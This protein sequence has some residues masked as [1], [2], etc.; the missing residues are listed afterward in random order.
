MCWNERSSA[1]RQ[2]RE[3]VFDPG[4]IGRTS[5]ALLSCLNLV[6]WFFPRLGF[7]SSF[8]DMYMERII[9]GSQTRVLT[10][11]Q[12]LDGWE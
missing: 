5:R 1:Q 6:A 12:L 2:S 7:F 3:L 10:A 8:D 4:A 11:T 9:A